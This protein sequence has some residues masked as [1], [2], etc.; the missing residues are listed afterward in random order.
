VEVQAFTRAR[1]EAVRFGPQ[2]PVLLAGDGLEIPLSTVV[3][4]RR[5]DQD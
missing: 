2:G 5:P 3:E 4:V 1:I